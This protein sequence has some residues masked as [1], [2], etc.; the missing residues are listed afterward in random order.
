MLKSLLLIS[1]AVVGGIYLTSDEGKDA[2]KA[3]KKRTANFDPIIKELKDQVRQVLDDAQDVDSDA[4]RAN[5][6]KLG[7]EA[8]KV[9]LKINTD[10]AAEEVSKAIKVASKKIRLAMNNIEDAPKKRKSQSKTRTI[11]IKRSPQS[12]TRT[13]TVKKT[14]Q[15]KTR[16]VKKASK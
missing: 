12:K 14:S 9:L 4:L 2:R 3:I 5:I 8:K 16:V 11:T 7:V 10:S 1:V 13:T 15:S 6:S